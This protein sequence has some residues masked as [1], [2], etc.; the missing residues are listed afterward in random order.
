[1]LNRSSASVYLKSHALKYSDGFTVSYSIELVGIN[2]YGNKKCSKGSFKILYG[3][4][5][6]GR[7]INF[8][9]ASSQNMKYKY[10][11]NNTLIV[12][13]RLDIMGPVTAAEIPRTIASQ[14]EKLFKNE[15]FSDFTLITIEGTE[16]PVHK[17]SERISMALAGI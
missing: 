2:S 7:L 8:K 14:Y 5:R 6:M 3:E 11:R 9:E 10:L 17:N 4:D 12:G 16:V 15:K 1:M 13:I